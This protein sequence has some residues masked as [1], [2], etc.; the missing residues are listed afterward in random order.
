MAFNNLDPI[1]RIGNYLLLFITF[2]LFYITII[3]ILYYI[4]IVK[5]VI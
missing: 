5:I 1:I 2:T 3:I 4:Y